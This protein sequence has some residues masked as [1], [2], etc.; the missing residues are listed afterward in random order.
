MKVQPPPTI[1]IG[2]PQDDYLRA[3]ERAGAFTW[4]V[5][6]ARD[7]P[8]AVASACD[9]IL[10]AGGA[11]VDPVCYGATERHATVTTDPRRDEFELA[12]ACQALSQQI[13]VLGICRG[14]QVLN[15]AAGGTLV[16]DLPSERSSAP[17]HRVT[18]PVDQIAHNVSISPGSRLASLVG[19]G[20]VPVNSRHHQAVKNV[21]P[22]FHIVAAAPDGVIEGIERPDLPFCVGVQW[23]PENFWRSG[24]FASLFDGFIDAARTRRRRRM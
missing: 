8:T 9:G 12:L 18:A 19:D 10:L 5:D 1:A 14:V 22:G 3:L 7:N 2:W 4:V 16:Q 20:T 6:P 11:D 21:A 24:Q 23:H 13:P 15:V 17:N